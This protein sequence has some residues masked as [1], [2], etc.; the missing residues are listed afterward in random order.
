[1]SKLNDQIKTILPI[2]SSKVTFR[3]NHLIIEIMFLAVHFFK[4]KT[5]Y[6]NMNLLKKFR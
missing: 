2:Y 6:K 1:M 5:K 3:E 4:L